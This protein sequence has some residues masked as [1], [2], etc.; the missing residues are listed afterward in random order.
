[1]SYSR[2]DSEGRFYIYM[3]VP[4]EVYVIHKTLGRDIVFKPGDEV[5][6]DNALAL[7]A[8]LSDYLSSEQINIQT[9]STPLD[10]LISPVFGIGRGGIT[11]PERD[12]LFQVHG[13]ELIAAWEW[14]RTLKQLR[15]ELD[16][17]IK[18]A[19]A[20][21]AEASTWSLGSASSR[22]NELKR[23]REMIPS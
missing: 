2:A 8:A 11:T 20:D 1:M 4:G 3:A 14:L 17:R 5:S 10:R 7:T 19:E 12:R 9:P 23:L 21:C 6:H 13:H 15:D 18:I 16:E 22:L